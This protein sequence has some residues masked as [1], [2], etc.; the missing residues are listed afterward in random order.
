MVGIIE[1]IMGI[2]KTTIKD[3][4]I[5]PLR[6]IA[7]DRG[8]VLHMLRCDADE[9]T[10][11][12]E[13][14]FSE[15]VPHAIKAWKKHTIQTQNIAV[16]VGKIRLVIFDDRKKTN[17]QGELMILD[18]GRPEA[19]QRVKIPPGIW[20]G[21]TCISKTTAL[22]VNCAD[23]PHN[24]SENLLRDVNDPYIPYSWIENKKIK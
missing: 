18:L 14:Y 7:D 9:F 4:S 11:F 13:C 5:T 8:S 12:G 1:L 2:L 6:E 19:Y 24:Q 3:V 20:Y 21:F 10:Q 16:P 23:H 15:V 17:P 22:I